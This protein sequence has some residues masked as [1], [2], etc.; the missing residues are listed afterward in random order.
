[1][2]P[3]EVWEQRRH[4]LDEYLADQAYDRLR[5][6][7]DNYHQELR[8][9]CKFCREEQQKCPRCGDELDTDMG[10]RDPNCPGGK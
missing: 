3:R 2:T 8:D 4:D 6:V 1:M 10:C 7:H 5:E 9:D